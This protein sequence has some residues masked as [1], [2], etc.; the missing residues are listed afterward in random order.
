[1]DSEKLLQL[2]AEAFD[3]I[4]H[5]YNELENGSGFAS[6]NWVIF[7]ETL[8]RELEKIKDV[9]EHKSTDEGCRKDGG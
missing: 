9:T 4:V 8:E 3:R 2:K 1:M 5:F 7:S 6:S